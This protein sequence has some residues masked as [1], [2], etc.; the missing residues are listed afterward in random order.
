VVEYVRRSG[1]REL[2]ELL[3]FYKCYR[4]FVRGKVLSFRLDQ[5]GLPE[6]EREELA[7]SARSY[8]DLATVYAGG[9]ERP[10][11]LVTCGV[12]G[13]GKST[14]ANALSRRLGMLVLSTDVIRKRRAGLQPTERAHRG[15]DQ[16]LYRAEVSRLTYTAMREEAAKWLR[17]GI[18]VILDGTFADREQRRMARRM[19][20][21]ARARFLLILTTCDEDE[22]LR[23][24][25][26]RSD[27]PN[28][29]SDATWEITQLIRRRFTPPDEVPPGEVYLDPSGGGDGDGVVG[30]LFEGAAPLTSSL[31]TRPSSA[32]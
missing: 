12:P 28:R 7:R 14:L 24:I 5:A 15:V 2:T 21:R 27:D 29:I 8:F 3:D 31:S 1:D 20:D 19:A 11:L 16:G 26:T 23:R 32:S 9:M 25:E 13:S 17:R 10:W 4:A 22:L 30:Y 6:A 18:S